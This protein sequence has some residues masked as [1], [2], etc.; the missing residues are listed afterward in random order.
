RADERVRQVDMDDPALGDPLR[1]VR[2]DLLVELAGPEA[3]ARIGRGE[4]DLDEQRKVRDEVLL[5]EE[6]EVEFSEDVA[7]AV[8]RGHLAGGAAGD[9]PR[10]ATDDRDLAATAYP[11]IG[12]G[13]AQV[14]PVGRRPVRFEG[15]LENLGRVAGSVR[16]L[17]ILRESGQLDG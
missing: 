11:E 9:A 17:G 3:S 4:F 6:G 13:K 16:A 10:P 14:E 7:E 15:H 8:L 1:E 5:L 2:S 12:D